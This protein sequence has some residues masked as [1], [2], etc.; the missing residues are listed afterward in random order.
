M[1]PN[2]LAV[3]ATM[4][5]LVAV[6]VLLWWFIDGE[7]RSNAWLDELSRRKHEPVVEGRDS[8]PVEDSPAAPAKEIGSA[9]L[10]ESDVPA[11]RESPD[12]GTV[13][14]GPGGRYRIMVSSHRHE[15]AAVFEARQLIERG[16]GAEVVATKVKDRGI[17]F[18]VVVSGGYPMLSA[19]REDLDTVRNLG[20]EGA[21]IERAADNE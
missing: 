20:Y 7:R 18:R 13:I 4:L 11:A 1:T 2:H 17:W 21:W 19:A 14:S 10:D 15:G 12:G 16:V 6:A 3:M 8:E 9:G 5:V